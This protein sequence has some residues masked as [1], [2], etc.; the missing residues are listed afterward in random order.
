MSD[1]LGQRR[2]W[3]FELAGHKTSTEPIS[4]PL[5]VKKQMGFGY[6][7]G[8]SASVVRWD[9]GISSYSRGSYIAMIQ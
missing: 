7:F 8:Y 3:V 1:R 9:N 5:L 6:V 2:N 4:C